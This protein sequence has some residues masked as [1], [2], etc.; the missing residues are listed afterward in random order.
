[1]ARRR[2][3]GTGG[4]GADGTAPAA[5]QSMAETR[6]GGYSGDGVSAAT[7]ASFEPGHPRRCRELRHQCVT[8][9]RR[10]RLQT[11]R[12][13]TK[14]G[15]GGM[16]GLASATPATGQRG[17][18]ARRDGGVGGH[19]GYGGEGV[20][21]GGTEGRRAAVD[22]PVEVGRWWFGRQPRRRERRRRRRRFAG[23]PGL[24][25]E[26]AAMGLRQLGQQHRDGHRNG[27]IGGGGADTSTTWR[28]RGTGNGGW[29]ETFGSGK[30]WR[31]RRERRWTRH[32]IGGTGGTGGFAEAHGAGDALAGAAATADRRSR[33]RWR[34]T[35]ARH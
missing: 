7:P 22:G 12:P 20:L 13:G 6:D 10:G 5:P 32:R 15:P 18:G 30:H 14:A 4:A 27:G 33:R 34:R 16:A 3:G 23:G 28:P 8:R 35:A 19:G 26:P 1:M 11:P 2:P 17:E 21:A 9:E 24:T 29:R 25:A 31:R